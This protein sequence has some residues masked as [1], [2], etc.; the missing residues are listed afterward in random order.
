LKHGELISPHSL[1]FV[2]AG[3]HVPAGEVAA[4]GARESSGAET[5]DGRALPKAIV[6][7]ASVERGLFRAGMSSSARA[8]EMSETQASAR[9][10]ASASRLLIKDSSTVRQKGRFGQEWA[11][12]L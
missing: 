9:T 5:A 1:V 10:Q 11:R 2:D 12:L 6:D 7:V 3:F 8:S 4:I